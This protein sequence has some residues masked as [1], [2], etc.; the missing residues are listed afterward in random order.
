MKPRA[1]HVSRPPGALAA[2]LEAAVSRRPRRSGFVEAVFAMLAAQDAMMRAYLLLVWRLLWKAA[3]DPARASCVRVVYACVAALLLSSFVARLAR[4]VP[5]V[6]GAAVYRL[7]LVGVLVESYLMLRDLLPL[8]RPDALDA[9]L[10]DLDLRLF[11]LEPSLWLSRLNVRPVVEWFSFFYFS[12]FFL[13]LAYLL[14]VIWCVKGSRQTTEFVLG[15]FIVFCVGQIGY[16]AVPAYGPIR[17]LDAQF[18]GPVDGGFFWGCVVRTVEA[19][20]A[21]K[22]VFPSLHTAVPSWFTLFALHQART[23]PRWRWPARVT[24]FFA[25]NIIFSTVFLRWHYAI[26]VVAGLCLAMG[27]A[28]L[29]PR[30]ARV[31]EAWRKRHGYPGAWTFA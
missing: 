30:I 19:G 5:K 18:P 9:T 15:T 28:F 17:Y 1:S 23:D 16:M 12:Y 6:V 27:A 13:G 8:V 2:S 7:C 10:L 24:G 29:A 21:M 22:D 20:G 3:P 14:A 25:A 4:G 31:E 26:D 11:G